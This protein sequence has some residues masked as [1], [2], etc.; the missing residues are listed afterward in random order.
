MFGSG[1]ARIEFTAQRAV[2]GS[3]LI[4]RELQTLVRLQQNEIAF[5][6]IEAGLAG[7]RLDGELTFR[8]D[9]ADL[10][11]HA[12][13]ALADVDGSA[14]MAATAGRH[15]LEGVLS[16]QAEADGAGSSPAA[17]VG[18]ING[19]ANVSL[20]NARLA[21]LNPRTFQAVIEAVDR[22]LEIEAAKV[23]GIARR[24]LGA[25]E[26]QVPRADG[27]VTIL[28]GRARVANLMLHGEGADVVLTVA[29]DFTTKSLELA[30]TL[31]GPPGDGAPG[32]DRPE[33]AIVLKGPVATARPALDTSAFATW[34]TL[35]SLD[36]ET[37]RMET[38]QPA[39]PG[40]PSPE[41]AR[42][43][44]RVRP[45]G[46]TP[47]RT[48]RSSEQPAAL[49]APMQLQ[50]V[51]PAKPATPRPRDVAPRPVPREEAAPRAPQPAASRPILER[52]FGGQP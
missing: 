36:R 50:P 25:G 33:L 1:P 24:S 41:P 4:A 19:A 28:N 29:A 17:L 12:R 46:H 48:D 38:S 22:G 30:V 20:K 52:L 26:L 18:S 2:F 10:A 31:A 43:P 16:L 32:T 47:A 37:R 3:G 45:S 51:A 49:A 34:L 7:G 21:G 14:V 9:G 39:L 8:R 6:N 13:I 23:N 44:P 40:P 15:P 35:R 5:D 27:A 42:P 11:V